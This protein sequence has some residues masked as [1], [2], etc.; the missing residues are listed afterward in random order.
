[1]GRELVAWA[2][3]KECNWRDFESYCCHVTCINYKIPRYVVSST[4]FF[5]LF[6]LG[7]DIL[8]SALFARSLCSSLQ[9]LHSLRTVLKLNIN[10]HKVV[11]VHDMKT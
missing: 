6:V 4:A 2:Q 11:S 7:P 1:M 3:R 8:V 10:K 5:I 9:V